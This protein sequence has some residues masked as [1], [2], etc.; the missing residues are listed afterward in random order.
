MESAPATIPVAEDVEECSPMVIDDWYT[1][2]DAEMAED[3]EF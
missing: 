2:E 3:G 1:E